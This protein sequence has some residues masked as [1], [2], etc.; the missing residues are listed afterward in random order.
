MISPVR[1]FM[2]TPRYHTYLHAS[3]AQR[4]AHGD[5]TR[6]WQLH[7]D[8]VGLAGAQ[9]SA[10]RPVDERHRKASANQHK[11]PHTAFPHAGAAHAKVL[12]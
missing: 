6:Q 11:Q 7:R 1:T 12:Q 4:C 2:H 3:D 5:A 10:T 8:L 9:S